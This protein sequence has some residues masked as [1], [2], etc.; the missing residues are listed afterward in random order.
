MPSTNFE[1]FSSFTASLRPIRICP[2]SNA[3]SA[4]GRPLAAQ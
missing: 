3:V 1:A 4:P 2:S